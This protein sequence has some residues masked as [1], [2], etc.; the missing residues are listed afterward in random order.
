[1]ETG[2][3]PGNP[4]ALKICSLIWLVSLFLP[5]SARAELVQRGD[6]HTIRLSATVVESAD[7]AH[8]RKKSD[9]RGCNIFFRHKPI[10]EEEEPF[11]PPQ[12]SEVWAIMRG[13][14]PQKIR[15]SPPG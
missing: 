3:R 8:C 12:L 11:E 7:Y 15:Q 1:M 4:L 14:N 13:V 6:P 2:I 9:G 10:I 5:A